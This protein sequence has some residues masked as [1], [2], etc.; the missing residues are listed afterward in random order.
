MKRLLILTGGCMA[1]AALWTSAPAMAADA[2]AQRFALQLQDGAPAYS[3]ALSPAVYEAS[4][5]GDLGDLRVFNGAGEAVPYALDAP[6]EPSR[7]PSALRPVRWFPVAS[8][9]AG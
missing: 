1:L 7:V 6:R 5:R 3:V 8:A 2:F 4:R 9:A